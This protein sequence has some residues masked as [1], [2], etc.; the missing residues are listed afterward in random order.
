MVRGCGKTHL[1]SIWR[2]RSG[3][4]VITA[5]ALFAGHVREWGPLAVEDVDVAEASPA[6]DA[7]LFAA[8]ESARPG[9]PVLLTGR[10]APTNWSCILP[11]LASRFAVLAAFPL[12]S[13][14]EA[15]LFALARKLFADRQ[16]LVPDAVI[17]RMLC[18]L[19]RS[20]GAIRDFVAEADAAALAAGRPINLS[21][22]R[23]LVAARAQRT[24]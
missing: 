22:V 14:D 24:P 20:P 15:L 5:S 13:P 21:L 2:D 7:G 9:A 4:R 23:A 18:S 3:A 16:L 1:V 8:L 19:E 6:R 11:D 10:E 17:E 12:W